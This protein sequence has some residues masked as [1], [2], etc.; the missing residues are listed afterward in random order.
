M[1]ERFCCP[2][3]FGDPGLRDNIFPDLE[4]TIGKCDFCHA[5]NAALVSPKDLRDAFDLVLG[6]YTI[7]PSGTALS[8]ALRSDWLLFEP[9]RL[10]DD[11]AQVLLGEIFDDGELVRKRFLPINDEGS[12]RVES[13]RQARQELM[14]SNRWFPTTPLDLRPIRSNLDT[15][16]INSSTLGSIWYRARLLTGATGYKRADMG[17]PPADLAAHGRANPAGIPYLYLGSTQHTAVSEVRPHPGEEASVARF[18][19]EDLGLVDLRTP[20][21][22]TSPFTLGDESEICELRNQLPLLEHLGRELSRPVIPR[23]APFEYIPSQYLCEYVKS[24]GFDGVVYSSSVSV[25]V[26]IAVFDPARAHPVS[27]KK[28]AISS[29]DVTLS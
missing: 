12:T 13:W 21:R 17:A 5:K 24:C 14:H 28:V 25:G 20:R 29:V 26:N 16:L 7:D 19:V 1:V 23:S 3:C 15:L 11:R 2:E 18:R 4:Q 22:T 10:D 8:S 9:G 27:V 6:S